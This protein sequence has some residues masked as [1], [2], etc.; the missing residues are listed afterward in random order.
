M[1]HE[2]LLAHPW[3]L[4]ALAGQPST[5][6]VKPDQTRTQDDSVTGTR[7]G[8]RDVHPRGNAR[9]YWPYWGS[10][11]KYGRGACVHFG[12]WVLVP[13]QGAAAGRDVAVCALELGYA[14]VLSALAGVA[15]YRCSVLPTKVFLLFGVYA[16]VN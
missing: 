15:E 4:R 16:C 9:L 12:A 14:W 3:E 8:G 6:Q 5:H 13:L 1:A 2:A 11:F 7:N 10:Y